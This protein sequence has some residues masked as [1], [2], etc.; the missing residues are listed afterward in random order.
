MGLARQHQ[1]LPLPVEECG[2]IGRYGD[3]EQGYT[4]LLHMGE[5]GVQAVGTAGQPV[6]QRLA[7]LEQRGLDP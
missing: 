6:P 2:P 1:G 7:H 4:A 3:L 5:E